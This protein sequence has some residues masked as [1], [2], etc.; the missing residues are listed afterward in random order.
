MK[1]AFDLSLH[2]LALKNFATFDD[3]T[4]LF[5]KNFNAIVGETGSGKSLILDALQLILGQRADRKLIRKDCDFT[6][7]EATFHCTNSYIKKYFNDVGFPFDDDEILIKRIIFKTGKTKSFLNHQGCS[8]Q[9]LTD[10]SRNF[11]DLVGQFENQKLLSENYQLALLDDY[12]G[13]KSLSRE[14]KEKFASLIETRNH[15]ESLRLQNTQIVQKLDY[16]NFQISEL[17]K[18]DPSVEDEHVLITQKKS[19]QDFEKNQELIIKINQIFE[20]GAD[21]DGLINSLNSLSSLLDPKMLSE[22]LVNQFHIA[23][24]TL[25]DINYAVNQSSSTELDPQELESTLQRLD[26]YQRLKRKFNTDTENLLTIYKDFVVQRDEIENTDKSIDLYEERLSSLQ[27]ECYELAKNLHIMRTE[28]AKRLSEE[29]TNEIQFLKMKGATID[30]RLSEKEELTS[31]GISVIAL[32]AETNPGEGF[33]KI[34]DIA[35]GGELSRILLSLRK[36]LA[37][38]DSISIFLFDEI[39]TGIGGETA[40]SIGR[41]LQNVSKDS[42]V[43]AITHL[44]Q[45]ATYANKLIFVEKKHIIENKIERT[46]SIVKEVE[47]EDISSSVSTMNPLS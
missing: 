43:I 44:P 26:D 15:L 47:G 38:K 36:V 8:L 13:K 30:I 21:G 19:F 6:V 17:E 24:D 46:I 41:T 20:G 14:Y 4:V 31:N 34:K 27:L 22:D 25:N 11:I 16:L 29:L 40:L 1:F 35:S 33:F 10:F 23:R 45:I 2:K 18:L 32:M 9:V 5:H 12:S 28:S 7:I 39:D 3:Q 42:Q 37:S